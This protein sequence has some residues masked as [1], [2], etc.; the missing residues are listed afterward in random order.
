M[1]AVLHIGIVFQISK[2]PAAHEYVRMVAWVGCNGLQAFVLPVDTVS[3][4]YHGKSDSRRIQAQ[5]N[6][7]A[8]L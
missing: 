2:Y 7:V 5:A 4:I 6:A 3:A 8:V 1:L